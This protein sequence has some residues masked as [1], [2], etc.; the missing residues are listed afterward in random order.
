MN[1]MKTQGPGWSPDGGAFWRK[2]G[3][4]YWED[5]DITENAIFRVSLYVA[6]ESDWHKYENYS[7]WSDEKR[8]AVKAEY[9]AKREAE[10]KEEL[11]RIERREHL[12]AIARIKLT[13]EEYN[14]VIDS[15]RGY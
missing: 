4:E 10:E 5:G 7:E 13:E 6:P 3:K 2:D 12:C 8:A 14:A 15:G 11:E 1:D 9:A